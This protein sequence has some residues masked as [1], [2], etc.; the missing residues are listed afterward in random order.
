MLLTSLPSWGTS[1]T[2]AE[3]Y[4]QAPAGADQVDLVGVSWVP[5][6]VGV[7]WFMDGFV[8]RGDLGDESSLHLIFSYVGFVDLI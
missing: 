5:R 8:L 2:D 1:G 6:S 7:D 3:N 4:T